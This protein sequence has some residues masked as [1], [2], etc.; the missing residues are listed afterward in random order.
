MAAPE[1]ADGDTVVAAAAVAQAQA[2]VLR[3]KKAAPKK[4]KM[5]KSA[6]KASVRRC[7]RARLWQQRVEVGEAS[8]FEVGGKNDDKSRARRPLKPSR[9]RRRV[10]KILL[11]PSRMNRLLARTL[12]AAPEGARCA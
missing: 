5:A 10:Y 9:Q 12:R 8:E 6:L 1:F 7:V 2:V 11:K 4:K 3:H